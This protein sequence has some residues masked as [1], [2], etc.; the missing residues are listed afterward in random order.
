MPDQTLQG[1]QI[2]PS[3]LRDADPNLSK[4]RFYSIGIVAANKPLNGMDIEVYPTE[5]LPMLDGYLDD[6]QETVKAEG[7]DASGKNYNAKVKMGNSIK[8][9]WLPFCDSQR[10]TA[11]NVRRGE[12]VMI[13][14]FGDA[15]KYYWTTLKNDNR[16]RKLETVIYAFSATQKESDPM[17]GDTT[18]FLEVSTHK[19]LVSFHT[20]QANGEAFGYD[21]Q[22]NADESRVILTDTAGNKFILNSPQTQLRMEN[23][24]GSFF[25]IT[26]KV[27]T[28][29]AADKIKFSTKDMEL[30]GSTIVTINTPDLRA[31]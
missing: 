1:T 28:G 20:S 24:D 10:L 3:G 25:D 4:L 8:A 12:G 15:D 29:Y 26:K 14:Q 27:M 7:T 6:A 30:N 13:Y 5:E 21:I 31:P 23:A 18:Y 2:D 17:N 9:Q 16:L 19:K 22:I 11:P